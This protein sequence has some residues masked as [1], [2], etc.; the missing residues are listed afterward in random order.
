[1][2]RLLFACLAGLA[3][4][5]TASAQDTLPDSPHPPVLVTPHAPLSSPT[6][7]PQVLAAPQS[8]PTTPPPRS[9]LIPSLANLA[10]P[11]ANCGK[12]PWRVDGEYL[13][14]WLK[15]NHIG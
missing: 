2:K 11:C 12:S 7:P 8:Y 10:A 14:W 1:M 5:S 6:P 15:P 4:G 9:A 13:L 3:A